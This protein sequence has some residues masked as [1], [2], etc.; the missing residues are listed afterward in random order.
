MEKCAH[1]RRAV[2]DL[3][4]L[5]NLRAILK[6]GIRM[7]SRRRKRLRSKMWLTNLPNLLPLKK[8]FLTNLAQFLTSLVQSKKTPRTF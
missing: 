1:T 3:L 7:R 6:E 8:R 2:E 4:V 5:I